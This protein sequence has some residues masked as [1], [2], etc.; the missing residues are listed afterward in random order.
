MKNECPLM[1]RHMKLQKRKT[2]KVKITN[3]QN[4]RVDYHDELSRRDLEWIQTC[5]HLQI[6]IIEVN[7]T[8]VEEDDGVE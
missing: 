1:E 3:S 5:P 7:L 2:Y 6:E 8:D 4:Q